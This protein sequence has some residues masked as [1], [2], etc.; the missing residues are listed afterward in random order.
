[1]AGGFIFYIWQNNHRSLVPPREDLSPDMVFSEDKINVLIV[2]KDVADSGSS[3]EGGRA[4]TIIIVSVDLV[5]KSMFLLSIP[6]DTLVDIP[7]RG[8]DK[9]NHSYFFGGIDLLTQC[10]EKLLNVPVDYY[11]ITDFLGFKDI[12]DTLGGVV[13]DVD[14]K[15][16]YH[17]YDGVIYI[18]AGLQ[19]LDG[20]LALQYVRYRHD[21]L[22]DITRT[23]RQQNFLLSLAREIMATENIGKLYRVI[24]KIRETIDTDFTTAQLAKLAVLFSGMGIESLASDTL[25]GDF[26]TI[27]NISYWQPRMKEIQVIVQREFGY[28]MPE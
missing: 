23:Q 18:E 6:R 8:K 28:S 1:V 20:D 12:V 16:D 15:M 2:G 14:K 19:R 5:N 7:G 3:N 11:A 10:V 21:P 22:G 25:P 26:A 13:I 24:P 27:K 4:D 17:T 9:I